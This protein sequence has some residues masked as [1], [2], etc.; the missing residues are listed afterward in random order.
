MSDALARALAAGFTAA[1]LDLIAPYLTRRAIT[2]RATSRRDAEQA[3]TRLGDA[4]TAARELLAIA[5]G[6][7]YR[8]TATH[9]GRRCQ[10]TVGHTRAHYSPEFPPIEWRDGQPAARVPGSSAE[11]YCVPVAGQVD[12]YRVRNTTGREALMHR[13]DNGWRVLYPVAGPG[14][15]DLLS[16]IDAHC[17]PAAAARR[18]VYL[19]DLLD[20]TG[21]PA[22]RSDESIGRPES[23]GTHPEALPATADEWT[24]RHNA[25]VSTASATTD[26]AAAERSVTR[27]RAANPGDP[28]T[29]MHRTVTPWTEA[30]ESGPAAGSDTAET[31][32]SEPATAVRWDAGRQNGKRTEAELLD[33]AAREHDKVCSCDPRY[34]MSCPR[35][36]AAILAAGRVD[37]G[38]R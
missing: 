15:P 2:A 17:D 27:C 20:T 12:A 30:A 34:L 26:R 11:P 4:V 38:E 10:W 5:I 7:I 18:A 14:T 6:D 37:P 29:L 13:T 24:W 3:L 1:E 36:A 21:G 31:R 19:L 28:V 22:V 25:Y 16:T 35:M 32:A 23:I 8:C 33:R 9:T